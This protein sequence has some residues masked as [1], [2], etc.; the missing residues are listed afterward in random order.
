MRTTTKLGTALDFA[1]AHHDLLTTAAMRADG[2]C[3]RDIRQ[4]LADRVIERIIRGLY[5]LAGS[6]TRLQDIAA[7]LLRND[8]AHA[9]HV[10]CLYVHGI[11]I[12]PPRKPHFTMP[13]GHGEATRLGIAH[14]SPLLPVDRTVV[15][16]LRAT[17]L[18]RA[19]VDSAEVL[20]V[21][22]LAEV[23]N[24]AVSRKMVTIPEILGAGGRVEAAPGR[25]GL[26]RLRDVLSTWTDAIEPDSVAEAALIRRVRSFGVPAPV[27]QH[28]VFDEDGTFVARL[29]LA[30]PDR[31]VGREY[32]SAKWHRPDKVEDDE[33]RLQRLEA[34][35]WSMDNVYRYQ[36]QPNEVEWLRELAA[37]LGLGRR[38][39]A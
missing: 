35:G 27:T 9:S 1:R 26:G 37:E 7:C 17:T 8:D 29:D 28:E 23:V 24:E 33:L 34:L 30:W 39:S 11:D 19:I 3:P 12:R 13:E 38:Q 14:R 31:M 10:S 18:A 21:E 22:R 36:L 5:R 16:G 4:L 15:N 20:D 2:L 32:V 6:R 25:V